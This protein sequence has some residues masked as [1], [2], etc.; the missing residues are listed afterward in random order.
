[1]TKSFD[2]ISTDGVDALLDGLGERFNET[3]K[4][5]SRTDGTTARRQNGTTAR[6]QEAPAKEDTRSKYT[7]LLD[8]DDAVSFD[9][10]ALGLR[11]QLGR[12]VD[13][14][15]VVRAMIQLA[16]ERSDIREDLA[17]YLGAPTPGDDD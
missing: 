4:P 7:L 2:P 14:S 12:A 13:K 9:A 1:M 16:T 6:R 11:R 10:L 15:K 5:K 8:Q 17:L 3:T